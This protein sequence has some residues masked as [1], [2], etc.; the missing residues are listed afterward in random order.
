MQLL[1]RW[2][3]HLIGGRVGFR[4]RAICLVMCKLSY[5][6]VLD[7]KM[8]ASHWKC[9]RCLKEGKHMRFKLR[10]LLHGADN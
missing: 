7:R 1:K 2:W 4:R 10:S 8:P 6:D 9:Y 5:K 3:F